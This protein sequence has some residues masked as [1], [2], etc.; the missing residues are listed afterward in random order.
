M[1]GEKEGDLA[2]KDSWRG[3]K[4]LKGVIEVF[5]TVTRGPELGDKAPRDVIGGVGAI[6]C[7]V[8]RSFPRWRRSSVPIPPLFH[9]SWPVF[10]SRPVTGRVQIT[11]VVCVTGSSFPPSL[12]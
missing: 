9:P 3:G 8:G 10:L 5:I 7:L 6:F 12:Q 2:N 4:P 1:E 11:S